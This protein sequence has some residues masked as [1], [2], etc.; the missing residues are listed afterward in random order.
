MPLQILALIFKF[1]ELKCLNF[2]L[3]DISLSEIL[4]LSFI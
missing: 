3:I 2:S 4:V 1:L